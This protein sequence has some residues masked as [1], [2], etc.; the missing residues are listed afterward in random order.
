MRR[1]LLLVLGS[2]LSFSG[3][4]GTLT[5]EQRRGDLDGVRRL[6]EFL[7]EAA[8]LT[9]LR[10]AVNGLA[11]LENNVDLRAGR[12]AIS[13]MG[14]SRRILQLKSM[15]GSFQLKMDAD[16]IAEI[17]LDSENAGL[18]RFVDAEG[19]KH[20]SLL[21]LGDDV[22]ARSQILLGRWTSRV[23]LK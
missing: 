22:E 12:A 15:D 20:L 2:G 4:W 19:R 18:V 3:P 21:M 13:V 1:A 9:P 11:M 14:T 5:P 17:Q 16:A 10:F 23:R 7:F 8:Q 6:G